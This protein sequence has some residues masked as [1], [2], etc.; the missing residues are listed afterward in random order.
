MSPSKEQGLLR[1]NLMAKFE[2]IRLWIPI[3]IAW[4][5]SLRTMDLSL[6]A[7]A[8]RPVPSRPK[9]PPVADQSVFQGEH[10]LKLS[11]HSIAELGFQTDVCTMEHGPRQPWHVE[12][13]SNSF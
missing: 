7:P 13:L 11:V 9:V 8:A 5:T 6:N 2:W 3:E 12:E 1:C 10:L 4:L